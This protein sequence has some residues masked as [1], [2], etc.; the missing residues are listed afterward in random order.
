MAWL[1]ACGATAIA[2]AL[3]ACGSSEAR[4]GLAP[5]S[6]GA[7]TR[8]SASATANPPATTRVPPALAKEPVV[9]VPKGAP[10]T[11]LVIKD[12]ITGTGPVAHRLDTVTVN[13]V[14]VLY[15]DG[16]VFDSSWQRHTPFTTGLNSTAV[17]GGW[18]AGIAG[19]RVGGRRELIVPPSLAYGAS[20][21]PPQVPA[22]ATLVFVIDLLAVGPGTGT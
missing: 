4:I 11:R 14:G 5:A 10:P 21:N 8:D 3:A 15:A 13:Y 19:E 22:H 7:T 12:L 2:A 6:A 9:R 17:I 20:G 18:V 1:R 16:K